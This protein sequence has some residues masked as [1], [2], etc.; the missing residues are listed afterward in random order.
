MSIH[1]RGVLQLAELYGRPYVTLEESPA[2]LAHWQLVH[3]ESE[4]RLRA[5]HDPDY[6]ARWER[7]W[8]EQAILWKATQAAYQRQREEGDADA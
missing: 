3:G 4:A 5:L 1:P 2:L 8:P 6:E 7:E